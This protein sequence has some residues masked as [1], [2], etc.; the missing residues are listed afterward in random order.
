ML[1]PLGTAVWLAGWQAGIA[2]GQAL[3]AGTWWGMRIT[4]DSGLTAFR[5]PVQPAAVISLILLLGISEWLVRRS[6]KPGL[7][8]GV[9]ISILSMHTLL[10]S[11]MRVDLGQ[12]FFDLRLDTWAAI[13]LFTASLVFL[14]IVL[15][16]T[17]TKVVPELIEME[18]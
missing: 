1:L 11:L 6:E 13:F 17:K 15:S 4:D 7:Q 8:T 18:N 16:R 12:H 14:I 2:Y 9:M 5:I 3:P 10:F